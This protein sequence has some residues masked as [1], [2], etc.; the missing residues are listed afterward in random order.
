MF[1]S[2]FVCEIYGQRKLGY[3]FGEFIFKKTSEME[4]SISGNIFLSPLSRPS[5]SPMRLSTFSGRFLGFPAT[6]WYEIGLKIFISSS[7]TSLYKFY[8]SILHVGGEITMRKPLGI[9]FRVHGCRRRFR[10]NWPAPLIGLCSPR[11]Q[12]LSA[13]GPAPI[14]C[15]TAADRRNENSGHREL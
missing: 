14:R 3:Y 1:K 9:A 2:K 7:S 5:L 13:T 15:R 8:G 6:P 10:P 12:R 4:V 11:H